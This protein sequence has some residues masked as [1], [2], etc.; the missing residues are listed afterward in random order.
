MLKIQRVPGP[1]SG[2]SVSRRRFSPLRG[3]QARGVPAVERAA[4][5]LTRRA[6]RKEQWSASGAISVDMSLKFVRPQRKRPALMPVYPGRI[7]LVQAALFMSLELIALHQGTTDQAGAAGGA[8]LKAMQL[9]G[10]QHYLHAVPVVA[11]CSQRHPRYQCPGSNVTMRLLD[12]MKMKMAKTIVQA[13][14][15]NPHP[16]RRPLL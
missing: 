7:A 12:P 11:G 10:T 3:I 13:Q 6:G 2:A 8:L 16:P 9:M 14:V 15:Q 1:Q 4:I 5:R